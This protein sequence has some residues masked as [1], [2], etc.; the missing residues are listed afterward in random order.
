MIL[1]KACPRCGGDIRT[2]RDFYGAYKMCLQCG[3][4]VDVKESKEGAQRAERPS[5]KAA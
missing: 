5:R 3:H 1:F 4:N 2:E